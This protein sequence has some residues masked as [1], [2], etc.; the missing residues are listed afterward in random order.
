MTMQADAVSTIPNCKA[1]RKA[2]RGGRATR[3]MTMTTM[4]MR[5]VAEEM[6]G[7][8]K[9][10]ERVIWQKTRMPCHSLELRDGRGGEGGP[11]DR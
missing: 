8:R 7:R 11:K 10:D 4:M 5:R 3:M 6:V 2:D 1:R 9:D